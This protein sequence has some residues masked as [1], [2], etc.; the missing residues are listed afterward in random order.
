MA[1]MKKDTKNKPLS[2][3]AESESLPAK[4]EE[5]YLH[6]HSL[7]KLPAALADFTYSNFRKIADKVPF[8]QSDWA[9]ILHLSERTLQRYAKDNKSFEGI[10]VDRILQ[11]ENLI[12]LGLDTFNSANEFY[13]WLKK[14]KMVLG[15]ELSFEDLYHT[16][17]IREHFNQLQRIQHGIYS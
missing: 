17:G 4:V 12:D 7:K 3:Y 8:T 16:E 10:Y 9:N 5:P 14:P 11:V 2:N 6:Y 13:N 15:N 1:A